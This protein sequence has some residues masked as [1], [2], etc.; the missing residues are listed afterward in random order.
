MEPERIERLDDPRLDVYRNLKSTNATRD[1]RIFIAEGPTVVDRVLRSGFSVS[2]VVISDRKFASFSSRLSVDIP[3]YRL[4]QELAEE[5][6]GFAFHCGV[7]ACALR[8]PPLAPEH[9]LPAQGPALVV[10]GDRITDPENVGALIRIA[11]AFGAAGVIFGPGS[12]DPFSRRVLRVS[13]GNALFLPVAETQNIEDLLQELG[14]HHGMTIA[15]TLLDPIAQT[16]SEY[17]FAPRTVLVF[18]NEY[19]GISSGVKDRLN[20]RLTIPMLNG[21]DS[22]NVAV[23]AGIFLHQYRTCHPG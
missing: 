19:D 15:G 6:V 23:S 7:M 2:S 17:S 22:L 21:T 5:L 10:A 12:A 14:C 4:R 18:G 16:L 3:V 13:M 8:R 20:A 11:S 1:A 9:W